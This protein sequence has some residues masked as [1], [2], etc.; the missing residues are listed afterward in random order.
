VTDGEEGR[1]GPGRAGSG[2]GMP[3]PAV[4][5]LSDHLLGFYVGRGLTAPSPLAGTPDNWVDAGAWALGAATYVV[6]RGE[7]AIVY[8]TGTLPELGEWVRAYL[9]SE[10]GISRFTVVLSHWHLDHVAGNSGYRD[11]RILALEATRAALVENRAAIEAGT[12]WGQPGFEVVLPD[13]TFPDRIDLHLDD[14]RVELHRFDIHSRDGNLLYLP[15]ERCLLAGDALEDTL[16]YV[17]E[18]EGLPRHLAELQRL[19]AMEIDRVYPNHGDP[20]VIRGG[21]YTKALIDA[22]VEYV[23]S[24]LAGVQAPDYLERELETFLPSALATGSVSVWE[25]YRAVHRRNLELVR[26]HHAHRPTA[27]VPA[28]G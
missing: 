5:E 23:T 10:K 28:T 14:L 4:L 25:P 18:P 13:I 22:T 9:Q 6:H 11:C 16:T 3:A 1:R 12:L 20:G 8:D 2:S 19:R 17:V 21:G 27:E 15:E 7:R 24:L 26:G